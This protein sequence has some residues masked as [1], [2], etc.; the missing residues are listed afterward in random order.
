[1]YRFLI[2]RVSG[3]HPIRGRDDTAT[4]IYY[5]SPPPRTAITNDNDDDGRHSRDLV[6]GDR[7]VTGVLHETLYPR[8]KALTKLAKSAVDKPA[9]HY[10]PR[11]TP[12]DSFDAQDLALRQAP[13]S[14]PKTQRTKKSAKH[15][16]VVK[17]P[18]RDS[19]V[20]EDDE[21]EPEIVVTAPKPQESL[22]TVEPQDLLALPTIESQDSL[23]PSIPIITKTEPQTVITSTEPFTHRGDGS[24]ASPKRRKLSPSPSSSS[25]AKSAPARRS[26]LR[27]E[28]ESRFAKP[29]TPP[30][31]AMSAPTPRG[32]S[33]A[34]VRSTD[35]KSSRRSRGGSGII[36]DDLTIDS[37]FGKDADDPDDVE[38]LY[39]DGKWYAVVDGLGRP[40]WA[41]DVRPK[42]KMVAPTPRRSTGGWRNR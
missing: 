38:Y 17:P 28:S 33:V 32:E 4:R 23:S 22:A 24:R 14:L 10:E 18:R 2:G 21:P 20:S 39:K 37:K 42:V 36:K 30:A 6:Y 9:V 8:S 3:D 40:A 7:G 11:H 27:A 34:S 25:P 29:K 12:A 19:A 13:T 5:Q 35:S 1:M 41:L 31:S 26:K 16:K 15:V